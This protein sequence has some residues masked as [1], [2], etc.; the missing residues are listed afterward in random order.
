MGRI[1]KIAACIVCLA[2]L[3]S[4]SA[5][6]Q[7]FPS[8]PITWINA[9][10]TPVMDPLARLLADAITKRTGA[11]IIIEP[12]ATGQ[13]VLANTAVGNARPDGYTL[14]LTYM[15]SLLVVPLTTAGVAYNPVKD[16]T[17]I[18]RIWGFNVGFVA[19]Q[20]IGVSN[21]AEFISMGKAKP[22]SLRVGYPGAT[23]RL[24]LGMIR[25]QSGAQF[26]EV[27]YS[28]V[29]QLQAALLAGEVDVVMGSIASYEPLIKAGKAWPMAVG[30]LKRDSS[31]PT[32]PTVAEL[33]T[34][35]DLTSW[36]GFVAPVGTPRSVVEWL[37]NEIGAVMSTPDFKEVVM[38]AGLDPY[39]DTPEE[40]S[41]S[42]N[43]TYATFEK[44]I[45]EYGIKD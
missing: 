16:F 41:K 21:F 30:A 43:R 24:G 31:R 28:T 18:A 37:S 9:A 36:I 19:R 26:L 44:V 13:G 27:P 6:A 34:N 8:R 15:G 45:K 38:R 2:S 23:N 32:V 20:S 42:L 40:F 4:G 14:G 25:S 33:V 5:C 7:T 12:R 17:P 1:W 39:T 29:P 35:F 22:G 11:V 3:G 10:S